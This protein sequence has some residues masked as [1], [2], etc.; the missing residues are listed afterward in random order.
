MED[1]KPPNKQS[2][3]QKKIKADDGSDFEVPEVIGEEE[4]AQ[5]KINTIAGEQATKLRPASKSRRL[6]KWLLLSKK[7]WIIAGAIVAILIGGGVALAWPQ[8][9]TAPPKPVHHVAIPKPAPKPT[10]V[11]SKLTGLPVA[12]S[13]NQN[14]ITAIMIENSTFARPQ[15][16]LDQAGVVFEA[17]AE[18]GITRFA[19]L[20]QDTAP[21]YVG[22]IRSVRPYYLSWL[23]GFNAPVAHVGGSP[24]AIQDL[25]SWGMK[26]MDQ[27]YYSSYYTRITS[28]AAPHNVYT[29]IA[30][31]N[32]LEN[33][34]GFATSDFT[35]FLRKAQQASKT[36]SPTTIDFAI[37]SS[38]YNVEYQYDAAN[39]DY[40]RSEGGA[41]HMQ[42]D[43]AGTQTQIAPKVVV[44]MVM[45][46]SLES[47]GLHNQY[48]T[49]GSGTA[50]VF[51][52]GTVTV[53][54][55]SK[56]ANNAQITF[57]DD[58][59]KTLYLDD[60]YTWLTALGSKS[61]VSY[62]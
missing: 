32:A 8:K 10:T 18:G 56:S 62:K 40:K 6:P 53:G 22:P 13:V 54:T 20:F 1:I 35:G 2:A 43:Q 21:S 41:A 50:Y 19:A 39:N 46:N 29:S 52:D 15:S 27:F 47:D 28:R 48:G 17:I 14:P 34:K 51:Q 30:E 4:D 12:P 57:A 36:P 49:V 60:G 5:D 31:L 38:D 61:D 11:P 58:S 3:E 33:A 7:Q 44:A 24:E 25:T 9:K 45:P 26:N 37:S 16:G 23:D 59:G 55:W 42:V